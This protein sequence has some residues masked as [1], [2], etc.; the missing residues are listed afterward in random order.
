MPDGAMLRTARKVR[1]ELKT[2]AGRY[3]SLCRL[4]VRRS[5]EYPTEETEIVIE[6]F[7]RSGNT[8]AVVAFLA[9]QPR[10]VSVAHHVHA[11]A[12]V[13]TASRL[14]IPALL[15]IREPE[16]AV[17]STVIRYPHVSIGQAL[18][19]FARFHAPLV[20]RRGSFVVGRF[21]EVVTDLGMVIRRVNA[22]FGTSFAEFE[23][24]PENV[25]EALATVDR[26]DQ[27]AMGE[28]EELDRGRARPT[29]KRARL[30]DV[31]RRRYRSAGLSKAR[32][33]ADRLFAAL[34]SD[35]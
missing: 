2:I 18:R 7:P 30:K 11:P 29:T 27:G 20:A 35:G 23:P 5:G 15:L 33:R 21:E 34:T 24:S 14:G 13:I 19:G 31:L 10:L 28:G 32:A 3:P 9:A 12:P 25:E 8:F 22:V 26:W 6:G 4:L 1:W 16:E 17:L